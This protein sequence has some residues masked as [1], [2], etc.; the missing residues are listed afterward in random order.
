V[1][2]DSI[3]RYDKYIYIYHLG[4]TG[5][6]VGA[7]G[8]KKHHSDTVKVLSKMYRIYKEFLDTSGADS[9]YGS[10]SGKADTEYTNSGKFSSKN[11]DSDNIGAGKVDTDYA[12]IGNAN[13][14]SSRNAKLKLLQKGLVF[15]ADLVFVAYLVTGT[16]EAKA[17]LKAFDGELRDK[18]TEIDRLIGSNKKIRIIRASGFLLYNVMSNLIRR[19]YE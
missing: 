10:V 9:D 11:D 15:I 18:Y 8:L 3:Q 4:V 12:G 16:P 1:A 13:I 17:E 2:A 14:I 19:R 5:Q 7:E 6:S